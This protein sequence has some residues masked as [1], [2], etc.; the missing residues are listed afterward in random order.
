MPCEL[1]LPR[2]AQVGDVDDRIC[3]AGRD[4]VTRERNGAA[5][6]R[7]PDDRLDDCRLS[8]VP[9]VHFTAR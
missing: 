5:A 7:M 2:M 9:Q 3:A 1:R 6:V 4:S 8:D